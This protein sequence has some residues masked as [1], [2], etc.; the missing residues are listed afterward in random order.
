MVGSK[1]HH[2][3]IIKKLGAGGQGTVYQAL[4]TKLDRK[5]VIK[6]LPPEL[7]SRTANFKRFEREAK[8][9]SQLDH[10]N[11]C[12]IYDFHEDDGTFYIA[13]QYVSGK[14]VRQLV[15][16]RPLE[17]VSALQITIQVCD[18]LA[19]AHSKNI[20]HR[21]IKAGNVMV[22]EAGQV[23]ILDFGLAKLMQDEPAEHTKGVDRTELTELG[24]PYGTATYA[25]PEQAKGEKTDHR[26]DIFSSGVL[27]Y[28]LLT[29]IWAF[30]GKTV[31]DVRHQVLYGTPV[32]LAEMRPDPVPPR[33]QEVVDK[34]LAKDPKDRYQKIAKMRDDL[35]DVLQELTGIPS[36]HSSNLVPRHL[37]NESPVKRAWNWLTGKST[38]DSSTQT[39]PSNAP[40]ITPTYSPETTLTATGREKKSVAILPFKNLSKNPSTDYYEFALADAVITELAKLRSLVVR[41][42]SVIAKYQGKEY[43][44]RE[45]GREMAVHAVLTAGFISAGDKI[46]VTPQLLDVQSGEILWSDRIDAENHDILA[47]QDTIAQRILDGL[48]L[49]LSDQEQEILGR[50][51]TDNAEAYE[52]YLRGRDNFGRFIF[53]TVAESDCEAAIENFKHAIELDPEF[54]LAYSGL[55]ACYANRIFKGMG[56]AEDYTYAESAFSK[57]FK[58]DPNVSE[59]RVLMVMIYMARG[60][61]Q[62]ARE[63]IKL[64]Q[65]QFPNEAP[66]YFVKG[67]IMRLDGEY[68]ESLKAYQ[69]LVRLDPAARVVASYNRARI[70][71]YRGEYKRALE[72]L[73]KGAKAEPNHPMIKIFRSATLFYMGE[74]DEAIATMREVLS[75]NPKMEGIKPLFGIFLARNGDFEEARAQLTDEALAISK[76]DHDMAYWVGATYALLGEIDDAFKWLNLAIKLGNENRP[77]YETDKSLD[78]LR[79]DERFK[80]LLAKLEGRSAAA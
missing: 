5:V 16:G 53:Q 8:L 4:D 60:E 38:G 62:K 72:E 40:Q 26:A 44:E 37:D 19:Y 27:L 43:D 29:G 68:D 17:L 71:N 70:Y 21:D 28:E 25:A 78:P 18:A 24:I 35:R 49:E 32:P 59:A 6:V 10:P 1:I 15:D 45:A 65:E 33:L 41:P 51:P 34:A 3:E 12:T 46:R 48:A 47:L 9:C 61:K 66:I 80:A 63:E 30:Q 14:N 76:A 13:M 73:D 67:V 79:N 2:Y 20:I 39:T 31:I 7:T 22:T 50:R 23:R 57:A 77:L 55:G 74:V 75:K 52:E 56:E 42:S 54:A 64:L 58:Y 11:I 36:G 69:K